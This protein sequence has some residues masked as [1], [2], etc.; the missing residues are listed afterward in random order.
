MVIFTHNYCTINA[1]YMEHK[2]NLSFWGF[3]GSKT[4]SYATDP[5]NRGHN[6]SV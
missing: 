4:G 1:F 6:Y 3:L 5:F 2:L